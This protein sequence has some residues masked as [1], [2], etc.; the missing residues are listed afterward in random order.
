MS[1]RALG[2]LLFA[3]DFLVALLAPILDIAGIRAQQIGNSTGSVP[4]VRSAP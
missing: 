1:A 2:A 3:L 4:L